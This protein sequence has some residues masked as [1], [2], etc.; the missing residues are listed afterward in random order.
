MLADEYQLREIYTYGKQPDLINEEQNRVVEENYLWKNFL[1]SVI[2][3][4]S[5]STGYKPWSVQWMRS[6]YQLSGYNEEVD[7]N[8]N[9]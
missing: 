7:N 5:D 1:H 8:S 4:S 3:S 2:E 6:V 9:L